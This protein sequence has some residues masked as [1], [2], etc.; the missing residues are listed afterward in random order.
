MSLSRGLGM[1]EC[2]LKLFQRRG[3]GAVNT[4]GVQV[5]VLQAE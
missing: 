5:Y 3:Y 4:F 1:Q 2:L